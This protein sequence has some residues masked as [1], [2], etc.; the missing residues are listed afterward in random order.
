MHRTSIIFN[1]VSQL[2]LHVHLYTRILVPK[3]GFSL[4]H[5]DFE[6]RPLVHVGSLNWTVEQA[7]L[8]VISTL[9][10]K[11]QVSFAKTPTPFRWSPVAEPRHLPRSTAQAS[12]PTAARRTHPSVR[13]PRLCPARAL[14]L[15]RLLRAPPAVPVI[16]EPPA[17]LRY[18]GQYKSLSS[19][20]L[21][22]SPP[23]QLMSDKIT[24]VCILYDATPVLYWVVTALWYIQ[25]FYGGLQ[26]NCA[27]R[28]SISN[29]LRY[30]NKE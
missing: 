15:C 16:P 20:L 13:A 12:A 26:Y 23:I 27:Y 10:Y 3:A 24:P 18:Q 28:S 17:A 2:Y 19:R 6:S 30:L 25:I 4:S 5:V 11:R 9:Q 29:Y 22:Y 1:L 7:R 14:R 21:V 8:L